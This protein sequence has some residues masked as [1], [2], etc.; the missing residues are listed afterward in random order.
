M[1]AK[2]TTSRTTLPSR[3]T[4][5]QLLLALNLYYRIPFGRQHRSAPEVIALAEA[6]RRTP[7][8][9]AM[10]LNNFTAIDPAEKGRVKGLQGASDLDRQV[11]AEF[12]D[13]AVPM[14]A[15]SE[16]LWEA[17]VG[18]AAPVGSDAAFAGPTEERRSATVRRAQGFFRRTVLGAYEQRCCVTGIALQE[19]L[20]ASHI[21]PWA[22]SEE[23]RVDPANGLCLSRLHDAAFDKALITFDEELRLVV[24]RRLREHFTNDAVRTHFEPYERKALRA[25]VR[26]RPAAQ[27]LARHRESF[28]EANR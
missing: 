10:K 1:A 6:I 5:E 19:F 26:F 12:H 22:A 2:R 8:A 9:V 11:W 24:G 27:Y 21:V 17:R 7:S 28:A 14:A 3:W 13:D 15:E 16:A 23:G 20:I 4:R 25:P 18:S